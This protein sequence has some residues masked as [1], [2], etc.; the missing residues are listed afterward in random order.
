MEKYSQ[1][2]NHL[3][4]GKLVLSGDGDQLN[5]KVS[6]I[7]DGAGG[8]GDKPNI[9]LTMA[10]RNSIN[11]LHDIGGG[12]SSEGGPATSNQTNHNVINDLIPYPSSAISTIIEKVNGTDSVYFESG[13]IV[14]HNP[15]TRSPGQPQSPLEGTKRRSKLESNRLKKAEA[16]SSKI[17]STTINLVLPLRPLLVKY[18]LYHNSRVMRNDDIVRIVKLLQEKREN[19]T[20]TEERQQPVQQCNQYV[21]VSF[22]EEEGDA[23]DGRETESAATDNH[24][25]RRPSTVAELTR[26]NQT[27]RGTV[28]QLSY[29]VEQMSKER[30]ATTLQMHSLSKTVTA[31]EAKIAELVA[32]REKVLADNDELRFAMR[33]IESLLADY[34][35]S[36]A[37]R[38]EEAAATRKDLAAA[39]VERTD[40]LSTLEQTRAELRTKDDLLAE[41]YRVNALNQQ[42]MA[43]ARAYCA[44]LAEQLT[45]SSAEAAATLLA[46]KTDLER[47][48]EEVR[49]EEAAKG[50]HRLLQERQSSRQR[51]QSV[52]ANCAD[53]RT[54][55]HAL[56]AS[57][58]EELQ[59]AMAE[60]TARKDDIVRRMEV[61]SLLS[62]CSRAHSVSNE[63]LGSPKPLS[64]L[65]TS[66]EDI[67]NEL[68]NI[69][70]SLTLP[71]PSADHR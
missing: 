33:N 68:Q 39:I 67:K 44:G 13:R 69:Q 3:R 52:Q 66:I 11:G 24:L 61:A 40:L 25:S 55:L 19:S 47:R 57:T 51:L 56:R 21:Q 14:N 30:S 8:R 43:S 60:W 63:R 36:L 31:R 62:S 23:S 16:I 4:N 49:S 10:Y 1:I 48:L 42:E 17:R 70:E 26:S 58:V 34:Q 12:G 35:S 29:I 5:L 53:L 15:T 45:R 54:N 18:K 59:S 37:A 41:L 46:T 38:A 71:V 9:P 65:H 20:Q 2:A 7:V 6:S 50:D 32:E 27:L 64:R 28:D 22:A